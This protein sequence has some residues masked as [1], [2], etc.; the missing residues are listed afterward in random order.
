MHSRQVT[1]IRDLGT[2]VEVSDDVKPGDRVILA[3]PVDL[4]DGSKVQ[5]RGAATTL[6]RR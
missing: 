4:D 5:I 6:R 3:P 1:E 2:E